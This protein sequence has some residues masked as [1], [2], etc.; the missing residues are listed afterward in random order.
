MKFKFKIT[1]YFDVA[2]YKNIR[3][4]IHHT[5]DQTIRNTQIKQIKNDC[6]SYVCKSVVYQL[7]VGGS[8]GFRIHRKRRDRL[9]GYRGSWEEVGDMD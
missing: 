6:N 3:F 4:P 7:V 5:S 2:A 1:V 9:V 8:H